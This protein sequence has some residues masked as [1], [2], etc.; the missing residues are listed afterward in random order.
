MDTDKKIEKLAQTLFNKGLAASL[1][2]AKAKAKDILGLS[3][4]STIDSSKQSDT[5]DTIM[6]SAGVDVV[7]KEINEPEKVAQATSEFSQQTG[8]GVSAQATDDVSSEEEA[9]ISESEENIS[10]SS[11]PFDEMVE[12]SAQSDEK[13]S[14]GNTGTDDALTETHEE[15]F[16]AEK[17]VDTAFTHRDIQLSSEGEEPAAQETDV[18]PFEDTREV[19]EDSGEAMEEELAEEVEEQGM[20]EDA[21]QMQDEDSL[22]SE[23]EEQGMQ[24]DR[25]EMQEEES[26]TEGIEQQDISEPISE[27]VRSE[28]ASAVEETQ[29][30]E[31]EDVSDEV[32][33]APQDV[34]QEVSSE[35]QK[36]DQ[37]TAAEEDSAE[38]D[39]SAEEVSE[40]PVDTVELTTSEGAGE[41][42][43]TPE[44]NVFSDVDNNKVEEEDAE[45]KKADEEKFI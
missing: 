5:V 8:E 24:E 11:T 32:E 19:S 14:A 40:K 41:S 1:W 2:D 30:A 3:T 42:S 9:D 21:S 29:E 22:V 20:Q 43:S 16:T 33:V 27:Q 17:E 31:P 25:S 34:A 44:G 28:D 4:D 38:Y 10:E 26:A 35:E 37:M 39:I 13:L 7:D 23:I 45:G 15:H 36:I 6:R 12:P 18:E